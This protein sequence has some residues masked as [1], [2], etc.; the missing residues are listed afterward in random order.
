MIAAAAA[1]ADTCFAAALVVAGVL[2]A[3]VLVGHL[4]KLN[5]RQ[6]RDADEDDR[7]QALMDEIRRHDD[8]TIHWRP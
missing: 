7:H 5:R 3:D 1:A 4:R 6:W 2:A 8:D